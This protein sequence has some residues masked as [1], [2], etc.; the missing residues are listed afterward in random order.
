MRT[1]RPDRSAQT[2]WLRGSVPAARL[3]AFGL[4]PASA[5]ARVA[6]SLVDD[7]TARGNHLNTGALGSSVLL[8]ALSAE[9]HPDVAHAIATQRTCPSW[10]YWFDHGA[11]TMWEMWEL[12]SRSRDH[13]FLGTVTQWL[14]ENV[15][16]LRPGDAGYRTFTVRPDA[17]TGVDWARTSIRTVRGRASV[18]W[19][20][21]GGR[22]R[23]VVEVPVG[24]EAEVHVPAARRAD[25]TA[26]R[27]AAYVR[28][29]RSHVVYRVPHGRW[30]FTGRP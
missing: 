17:R 2:A 30:E 26:A 6:Q 16:G 19:A 27:G 28:A 15:A 8:P 24:A 7:V 20:R 21:S 13:Y 11:D 5:R 1:R 12:D 3:S 18:D 29:E 9:G 4:A 25:T 14:Y 22:L 10:G 23:L